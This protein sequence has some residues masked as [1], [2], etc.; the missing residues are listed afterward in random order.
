MLFEKRSPIFS[1][2]RARAPRDNETYL[3]SSSAARYIYT[4]Y[5]YINQLGSR[6][7][8]HSRPSAKFEKRVLFIHTERAVNQWLWYIY[9][10]QRGV[11]ERSSERRILCCLY[12][13]KPL[14][15]RR[16]VGLA[17]RRFIDSLQVSRP[18]D[19]ATLLISVVLYYIP[20]RCSFYYSFDLALISLF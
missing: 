19:S 9:Y 14:K 18:C 20:T 13:L 10:S 16:Q 2:K 6:S 5:I 7:S 12:I 15:C 1:I 3:Q 17:R 4:I 8:Y 11:R